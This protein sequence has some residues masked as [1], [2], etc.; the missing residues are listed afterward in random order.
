MKFAMTEQ[1]EVQK[2]NFD[3][4][5]RVIPLPTLSPG[6]RVW[7]KEPTEVE[8]EVVRPIGPRSYAVRTPMGIR[9]RNRKHLN[10]RS[11]IPT[12]RPRNNLAVPS[13]LPDPVDDKVQMDLDPA[14]VRPQVTTTQS[15]SPLPLSSVARSNHEGATT[16]SGR[17]L[18]VPKRLDL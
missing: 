7:V 1:K 4:R 5:H 14:P 3:R 16:R 12:S 8:A 15:A 17:V 10:R 13:T 2:K 11:L 9:R 6:D 18:K